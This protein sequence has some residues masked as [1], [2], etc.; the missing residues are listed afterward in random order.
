M[1]RWLRELPMAK[2]RHWRFSQPNQEAD[3]GY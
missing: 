1:E 3:G 2:F